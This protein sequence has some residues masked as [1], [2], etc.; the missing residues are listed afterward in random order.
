MTDLRKKYISYLRY[1]NYSAHTIKHYSTCLIQLSKHYNQSPDKLTRDQ[2]VTY[3]YYLVEEKQVSAVYLNQL[4]SAYKILLV[5]ILRREWEDFSIRR[6]KLDK[7]LPVVL[8]QEE[9][10]RILD[11]ISNVKHRTFVSLI[12]SCGLRLDELCNLKVTDIDSTRM[13]IHIRSGKGG[14]DRYVMLSEK[15]LHMLREY[16]KTY[17][18]KEYM[19]E[20]ETRGKAISRRT[21]QHTFSAAVTKSGIN[22][23]PCIHTLRHSFATH[24]LENGVN[25]I[26]IQKL[27]GHSNVKTTT[28]YTHLQSSPALIKSPFDDL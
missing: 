28:I 9:V 22:K 13:Q 24:L 12:Y 20:G 2:F 5:D 10:K 26:A 23:R 15:I 1:R 19:F 18:P 3:L 17:R 14:K 16:W 7:K 21:V 11:S 8:S 27:L 4:I 6:P 25:L